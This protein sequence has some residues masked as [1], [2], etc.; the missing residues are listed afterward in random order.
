MYYNYSLSKALY[1]QRYDISSITQQRINK[2]PFDYH[3]RKNIFKF[4]KHLNVDEYLNLNYN[5]TKYVKYVS[6]NIQ[7]L[8]KKKIPVENLDRNVLFKTY[9]FM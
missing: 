2:E 1:I 9:G 3:N 7:A 5:N 4:M 8:V 6:Y